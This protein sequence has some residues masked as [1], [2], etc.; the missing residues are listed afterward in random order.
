MCSIHLDSGILVVVALT[1]DQIGIQKQRSHL[2]TILDLPFD[3]VM[4][5]SLMLSGTHISPSFDVYE[6]FLHLFSL[7]RDP[8]TNPDENLCMSGTTPQGN[9]WP[10]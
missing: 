5:R 9:R 1:A 8:A 3:S 10:A 4:Q 6:Y 2:Q 7:A